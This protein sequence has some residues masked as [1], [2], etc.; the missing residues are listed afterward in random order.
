MTDFH[1]FGRLQQQLSGRTLDSEQNVAETVTEI[2]NALPKNKMKSAFYIER[3]DV[4]GSQTIVK[5]SILVRKNSTC[6]RL[7]IFEHQDPL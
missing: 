4:R 7:V 5:T 6:K 1:L 2:L 3:K